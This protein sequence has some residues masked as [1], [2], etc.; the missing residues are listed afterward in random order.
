MRVLLVK[1]ADR[2]H[3]MRT[4]QFITHRTSASGSPAR[5]STSTPRWPARIGC[6]RIRERAGG[7]GLRAPQPGGAQRH[8]APAGRAAGEQGG[9][10]LYRA[11][12]RRAKRK[13]AERGIDAACLGR[14]K[15][16]YSIWR[17][18]QR[19]QIGFEQLSDIFGFRVIVGREEDCYRALGV[20]H[21]DLAVRARPLQGF[22][23]DAQ[24][25]SYRSIHTTVVGP[26]RQRIEV[27]IRTQDMHDIAER[28]V[29]AHWRYR[30]RVGAQADDITA[31]SNG[32]A[33]W[34][35]CWSAAT[36]RRI[37]SNIPGSISIRTRSSASRRR[38]I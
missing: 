26:E 27:Q 16:P 1:L 23:L 13:L 32:C 17:K 34:W 25:N 4:L 3:N 37:S 2:L 30:E 29:A 31:L 5:R 15:T 12:R 18:L 28:G 19:K 7:A 14:E 36:Q 21:R 35:T 22:H 11:H 33:K 6:H 24:A 8:R 20:I 38:A 9:G 10:D